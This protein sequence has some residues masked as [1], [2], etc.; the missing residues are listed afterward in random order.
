M[1]TPLGMSNVC[2]IVINK[3]VHHFMKN[4]KDH[5]N[6]CLAWSRSS[7]RRIICELPGAG[8]NLEFTK[9]H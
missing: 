3:P 8:H 5:Q 7:L 6:I 2:L 4:A 1:I 9:V